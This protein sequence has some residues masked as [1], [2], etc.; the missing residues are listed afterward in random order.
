MASAFFLMRLND[1]I[2]YLKKIEATLAGTEDFQGTEHHQCKL[3]LW[4]YGDGGNE[5]LALQNPKAKEIFESLFEPHESFH[6]ASHQALE[7]KQAGDEEGAKLAI[8]EMYKLSQN[9]T[10]KLL[11]LDGI[12]II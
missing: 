7:N 5:V 6:N 4:L 2:Q 12:G 10:Q 11:E 3:G 9:L 8:T 1:H